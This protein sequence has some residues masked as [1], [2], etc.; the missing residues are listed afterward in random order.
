MKNKKL[1]FRSSGVLELSFALP[2]SR[3]G[4][5]QTSLTLLS[6]LHRFRSSDN[7]FTDENLH[8]K[9]SSELLVTP[10]LL[11]SKKS[12]TDENLYTKVSSELLVTPEL[13]NSKKA[14]NF[15]LH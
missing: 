6:L 11:N 8:T 13:L 7:S 2:L 9:V 14:N 3:L 10:E 12:F 15:I 1:G 5:V 4:R